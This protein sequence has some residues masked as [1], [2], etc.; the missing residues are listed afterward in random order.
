L[1]GITARDKINVGRG[2]GMKIKR[3]IA[4]REVTKEEIDR[5]IRGRVR[6]SL[7]ILDEYDVY[8]L[9]HAAEIARKMYGKG[10]FASDGFIVD[11]IPTGIRI[12][13]YDGANYTKD[14]KL[15]AR[16]F[17][18]WEDVVITLE[19]SEVDEKGCQ[20]NESQNRKPKLKLKRK[21]SLPKIPSI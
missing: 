8:G 14:R 16:G 17:I 9:D 13:I 1:T 11:G 2:D 3:K 12:R 6:N 10:G 19:Q 7:H 15:I 4:V 20:L 21:K 18:S 5:A